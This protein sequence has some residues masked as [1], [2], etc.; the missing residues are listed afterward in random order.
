MRDSISSFC[1]SPI[2]ESNNSLPRTQKTTLDYFGDFPVSAINVE[3]PPSPP[4]RTKKKVVAF[5]VGT[6]EEIPTLQIDYSP[7]E[8]PAYEEPPFIQPVQ[9]AG[10]E[11]PMFRE[12][13]YGKSEHPRPKISQRQKQHQ[14]PHEQ[15]SKE[16]QHHW[17]PTHWDAFSGEPTLGK[18]G[19]T[20]EV[21]PQ[22]TTFHKSAASASG[23]LNWG[24]EQLQAKTKIAQAQARSRMAGFSKP[25]SPQLNQLKDTEPWLRDA[26][27]RRGSSPRIHEKE[28]QEKHL[29]HPSNEHRRRSSHTE[30]MPTTV[31]TITAGGG[32]KTLPH[33]PPP[34]KQ[35]HQRPRREQRD[36]KPSPRLDTSI[37]TEP[38]S[39]SGVQFGGAT[40]KP[41]PGS[42]APSPHG[43][44]SDSPGDSPNARE[45][46]PAIILNKPQDDPQD[47]LNSEP[48]AAGDISSI[49]SR[50]R[51]T[52]N[53]MPIS[54]KPVRKPTP[55]ETA[56]DSD[57]VKQPP[58]SDPQDPL[59]RVQ[60]ME[61]KRDELGRRRINLQTVISELTRV[62]QPTSIAYDLAAKQEVKRTVLS[63]ENEIAEIK[64]EEH[65]L[66]LKIT[67]AWRRLDENSNGDG[68]NLWIKRVTS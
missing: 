43:S 17:H 58:A 56:Q 6:P 60:A 7:A 64:R 51:P 40:I 35:Y 1:V 54:K 36:F 46:P 66:G 19:K 2:D 59:S 20:G 9:H 67:R 27:A 15:P 3:D 48:K 33:R 65:D 61:S 12:P 42:P 63:M 41:K 52:P 16:R 37:D 4:G 5:A 18:V 31:T 11:A 68:S 30:F 14:A 49:M 26:K 55:A 21:D 28:K 13:H 32:P 34:S 24:R 47:S 45:S 38:F 50:H 39:D 62:I 44:P 10:P 8:S 53:G 23:F 29:K 57:T 22:Q 25:E